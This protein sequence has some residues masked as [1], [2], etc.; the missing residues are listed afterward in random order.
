MHRATITI[1]HQPPITNITNTNAIT[2]RRGVPRRHPGD[3]S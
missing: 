2:R 1:N 3:R